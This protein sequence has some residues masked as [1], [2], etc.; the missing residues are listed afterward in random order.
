M[1]DSFNIKNITSPNGATAEFATELGAICSS[2]ILNNRELLFQ[3]DFFWDKNSRKT[4]GGI[5][6]LFPICGRLERNG[7]LG[8]Y[9]YEEKLYEMSAHG[10]A[11]KMPWNVLEQKDDSEITFELS[12]TEETLKQYPFKFNILLNYKITDNSLTATVTFK[13]TGEKAMPFYAGFH[14]YFF[15]KLEQKENILF[16]AAPTYSIQY[17]EKCNDVIGTK[18]S[19]ELPLPITS[20]I[21]TDLLMRVNK[22]KEAELIFPNNYKINI[23][24]SNTEIDFP[25]IQ[26]YTLNDEPFFCV[27]PWMGAPNTLNSLTGSKWINADETKSV[28]MIIKI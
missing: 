25:Y 21:L 3:H 17:N 20:P 28:Q 23:S 6:F 19:P 7:K 2:L 16:N 1:H 10:F 24:S 12:D 4:R 26:L 22:N 18:I 14:P 5:P 13:N 27:E 9:L 11:D 8:T 15:T